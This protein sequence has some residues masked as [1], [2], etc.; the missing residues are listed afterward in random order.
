MPHALKEATD[1][2]AEAMGWSAA[3]WWRKAAERALKAMGNALEGAEAH[4]LAG[5]QEHTDD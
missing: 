5:A 1:S 2:A 4:T 3:V